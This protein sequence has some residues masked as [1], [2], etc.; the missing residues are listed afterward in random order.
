M[1]VN[2]LREKAPRAALSDRL[3]ELVLGYEFCA[4]H[5]TQQTHT[6]GTAKQRRLGHIRRLA[7]ARKA[8]RS[9]NYIALET[10][11]AQRTRALNTDC[12]FSIFSKADR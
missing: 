7:A 5:R 6:L 9:D 2:L 10:R 11:R 3:E 4:C 8:S 1:T 12:A